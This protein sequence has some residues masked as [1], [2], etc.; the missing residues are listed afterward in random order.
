MDTDRWKIGTTA[1]VVAAAVGVP[2]STQAGEWVPEATTIVDATGMTGGRPTLEFTI[3]TQG[4]ATPTKLN[5]LAYV[6]AL[7][8]SVRYAQREAPAGSS[9]VNEPW[10]IEEVTFAFNVPPAQFNWPALAMDP[11]TGRPYVAYT[12]DDNVWVSTR[13]GAAMGN[14][15]TASAWLCESISTVCEMPI[16]SLLETPQIELGGAFGMEADTLHILDV[17]TDLLDIRKDLET[18]QWSCSPVQSGVGPY[19]PFFM[20]D[21]TTIRYESD[22]RVRPLLTYRAAVKAEGESPEALFLRA[23]FDTVVPPY[24][25]WSLES[26]AGPVPTD[27]LFDLMPSVTL[28]DAGLSHPVPS[29]T[30]FGV[31][32]IASLPMWFFLVDEQDSATCGGGAQPTW[33]LMYRVAIGDGSSNWATP[34]PVYNGEPCWPSM[35]S[36]WGGHPYLTFVEQTTGDIMMTTRR[37]GPGWH[38]VEKVASTGVMPSLAY[39]YDEGSIAIAYQDKSEFEVVVVDGWWSEWGPPIEGL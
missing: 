24:P 16:T 2:N 33:D 32:A 39:D 13:V 5:G 9:L 36:G 35:D 21:S 1:V 8:Q 7:T 18:G 17:Q 20:A 30:G 34:E 11:V 15:G 3:A 14:C 26:I 31:P 23:L 4:F 12:H 19:S 28:L 37:P 27:T 38:P 10:T 22:D 6:D 25:L 29:I